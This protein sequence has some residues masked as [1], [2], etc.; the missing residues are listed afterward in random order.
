MEARIGF[1][2]LLQAEHDRKYVP[3]KKPPMALEVNFIYGNKLILSEKIFQI[4]YP[5]FQLLLSVAKIRIR[6]LGC[7]S[8]NILINN[9]FNNIELLLA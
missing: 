6:L 8:M 2:P 1:L 4:H 7:E 3:P 9:W 5:R